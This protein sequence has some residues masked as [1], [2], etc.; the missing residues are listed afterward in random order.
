[1]HSNSGGKHRPTTF[2]KERK[3][4]SI[5]VSETSYAFGLFCYENR[6]NRIQSRARSI[7]ESGQ[8]F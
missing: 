3:R 5:V 8:S 1:M 2:F 7:I 4:K 6:T